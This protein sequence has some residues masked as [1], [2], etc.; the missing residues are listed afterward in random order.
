MYFRYRSFAEQLQKLTQITV[1]LVY[2]RLLAN[3]CTVN[4][5]HYQA[6]LLNKYM[7]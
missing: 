4:T 3:S 2:F 1:K 6:D 7:F 5:N